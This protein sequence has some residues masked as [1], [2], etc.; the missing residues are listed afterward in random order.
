MR[1]FATFQWFSK[2]WIQMFVFVLN[3]PAPPASSLSS[4]NGRGDGGGAAGG[5]RFEGTAVGQGRVCF[6]GTAVGKQTN[7]AD[8][9]RKDKLCRCCQIGQCLLYSDVGSWY[10]HHTVRVLDMSL[11]F[12]GRPSAAKPA[13]ANALWRWPSPQKIS[14]MSKS[15]LTDLCWPDKYQFIQQLHGTRQK[16]AP[17]CTADMCEQ[18][19]RARNNICA[20]QLDMPNKK[21]PD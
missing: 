3:A 17:W 18:C 13:A 5:V 2:G 15:C 14:S 9:C 21:Q 8:H 1:D 4:R 12:V 19:P 7:C 11:G 6:E 16:S 20:A 10:Y